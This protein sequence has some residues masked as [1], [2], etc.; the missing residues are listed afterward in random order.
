MQLFI[1]SFDLM[2][3]FNENRNEKYDKGLSI[4]KGVTEMRWVMITRLNQG[5]FD[6]PPFQ[7]YVSLVLKLLPLLHPAQDSWMDQNLWVHRSHVDCHLAL[8]K[9]IKVIV[10]FFTILIHTSMTIFC[11]DCLD[12]VIF[13]PSWQNSS[14]LHM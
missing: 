3:H 7:C 5:D 13:I 4:T 10:T 9:E 2:L 11:K 14:I 12:K 1:Q 6:L 8:L